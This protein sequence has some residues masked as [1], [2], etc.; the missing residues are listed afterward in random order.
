MACSKTDW[1]LGRNE[2]GL[3]TF[4]AIL[5]V[6]DAIKSGDGVIDRLDDLDCCNAR[7]VHM[8]SVLH[9]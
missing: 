9:K 6:F 1:N 3:S 2:E 7:Q 8:D 5:S 4:D